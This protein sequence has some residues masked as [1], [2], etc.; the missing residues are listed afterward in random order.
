MIPVGSH[1]KVVY[2]FRGVHINRGDFPDVKAPLLFAGCTSLEAGLYSRF[3]FPPKD[4][5]AKVEGMSEEG[6]SHHLPMPDDAERKRRVRVAHTAVESVRNVA[7]TTSWGSPEH[8]Y[9]F[10]SGLWQTYFGK[11]Y[12]TWL[13]VVAGVEA[14]TSTD[15]WTNAKEI[16]ETLRHWLTVEGDTA[17]SPFV[18]TSTSLRHAFL[19]ATGGFNPS[20]AE[21]RSGALE[22]DGEGDEHVRIIGRVYIIQV[23]STELDQILMR[24]HEGVEIGDRDLLPAAVSRRK[25]A[26]AIDPTYPNENLD[27]RNDDEVVWFGEVPADYVIGCMDITRSDVRNLKPPKTEKSKVLY[28]KLSQGGSDE[29]L[30]EVW[31]TAID[32]KNVKKWVEGLIEGATWVE[33]K[34]PTLE[35]GK[36]RE[37]F[38]ERKNIVGAPSEGGNRSSIAGALHEGTP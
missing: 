18:A 5:Y 26:Q 16:F 7:E 20:Q 35:A 25:M 24:G 31:R 36:F 34:R 33:G 19:A 37:E 10:F 8:S 1:E 38:W 30:S 21:L 12:G 9:T 3:V 22:D 28:P 13:K 15:M 32:H 4:L 29:T 17:A 2:L 23:S 27:K 14:D 11:G 6:E